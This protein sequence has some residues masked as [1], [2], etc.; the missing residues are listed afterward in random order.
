MLVNIGSGVSILKVTGDNEFERVSGSSL[1]GGTFWGLAHL[2]TKSDSF[3][4][5]LSMCL[6]GDNSKVDMLV[7]DIYGSDYSKVGLPA[8][9]IAS[10]FAKKKKRKRE[11]KIN[12]IILHLLILEHSVGKTIRKGQDGKTQDFKSEDIARSLLFMISNNIGQIAYLNALRFGI[13]RIYFGG[14]FIRDHPITMGC[15]SYAINFWS[16]GKMNALFLKHEG[17]LGAIGCLI[18]QMAIVK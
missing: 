3:D 9:T 13:K 15:I 5:V 10:R 17:Y 2:L 6:K 16:S 11:K 8:N 7:G 18:S 14:F 12:L 4:E 1:G